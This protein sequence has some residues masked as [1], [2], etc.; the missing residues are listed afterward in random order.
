VVSVGSLSAGGSGKTPLAAAVVRIL[1]EAGERPAILSRGYRRTDSVD[2]VTVVSD[3]CRL[4]ADL[5]RAG[6]EPLMLAR[7][8]PRASVLVSPDRY[9]A[10]RLAELHLGATVHVLD[11]GFQ[12]F[13]LAR[14]LNIL[15]LDPDDLD[16]PRVL[17]AGRL[18]EPLSAARH[19]DVVVVA[20]PNLDRAAI[21]D[22]LGVPD[23]FTAIR[24]SGPAVEETDRA[25]AE[26][27]AGTRVVVVSGIARPERFEQESR[28]AGLEVTAAMSFRD[29]HPFTR[30]D[31]ATI[32]GRVLETNSAL[33]LTTEKD[34]VRL[35]PL[36][37]WPFRVAVRPQSV[38]V[39]PAA[40]FAALV[41]DRVRRR[42]ADRAGAGA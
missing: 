32:A 11:D 36:R 21:A 28:E 19:A 14:D 20:D 16:R 10:G 17:P 40:S 37:P 26:V 15:L 33:V 3:G 1:L 31:L 29:H 5:S 35:L 9:L 24:E 39:E 13:Q 12:H 7:M 34:F 38:R 6:D 30:Q 8:L 42:K 25:I 4:R 27:P 18:R 22:R 41:L 23:V 2:G